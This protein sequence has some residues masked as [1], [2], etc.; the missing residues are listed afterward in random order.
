VTRTRLEQCGSVFNSFNGPNFAFS[1]EGQGQTGPLQGNVGLPNDGDIEA[2]GTAT[3]LK[4][5]QHRGVNYVNSEVVNGVLAKLWPYKVCNYKEQKD[6]TEFPLPMLDRDSDG[7]ITGR[8]TNGTVA[9]WLPVGGR[10]V[11][12]YHCSW[13]ILHTLSMNGGPVLAE[14]ERSAFIEAILYLSSEFDCKVCRSNIVRITDLY[15]LPQGHL[16]VDFAKWF[17]RAHN[18]A[19]EHTYATHSP[20][21]Q[22]IDEMP[23][24]SND[25]RRWSMWGNARYMHPWFMTFRDAQKLWALPDDKALLV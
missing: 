8:Y 6:C 15:G 1:Y 20:S 2:G 23:Y 12:D 10:G 21:Q 11:L 9:S 19:N 14:E 22:Q 4:R 5:E 3:V 17:W 18:H 24:L 16:R 13:M 25:D 7:S